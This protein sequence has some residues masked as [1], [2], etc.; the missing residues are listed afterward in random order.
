MSSPRIDT[1]CHILPG[2]DDGCSQISE[3]LD[4]IRQFMAAGYV[5]SICTP[6][7]IPRAYPRNIPSQVREWVAELQQVL[8]ENGIDYQLWAGGE[9]VLDPDNWKW[10]ERDGVPTLGTSR[11][12]LMDWWG[13]TWPEFAD[14]VI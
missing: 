3:S 11:A 7:I 4:C 9:V 8:V 2:V 14:Q 6:H 10:F 13:P 12:V 1:H 5:G